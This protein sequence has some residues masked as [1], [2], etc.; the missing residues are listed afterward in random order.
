[1]SSAPNHIA[2]RTAHLQDV[3][4][5]FVDFGHRLIRLV[6]E[7]AEAGEMPVEKATKAYDRVTRSVRRS[8]ML[9][10]KL[11][12]PIKT[13]DRVAARKRI[14][15]VIE[16]NI[17]RHA[18]ESEAETLHREFLE[19][20]DTPDWEDDLGERPVDEIA[21]RPTSPNSA[22]APRSRSRTTA[23]ESTAATPPA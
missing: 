17:Q 5:D 16:D 14:I 13:V 11:A 8:I 2:D 20:L 15:R 4:N 19:R 18:E 6:V 23:P 1:M 22:F 12:E 10:H 3:L 7:Q 9:I 21:P